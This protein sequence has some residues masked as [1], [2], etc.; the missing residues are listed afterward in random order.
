MIVRSYCDVCEQPYVVLLEPSDL[1]LMKQI[2]SADGEQVP[3]PRL[4]GVYISL[5]SDTFKVPATAKM[6]LQLNG[7]Q[8]YKAVNGAGL[9]DEVAVTE[10]H[11][12]KL[13]IGAEVVAVSTEAVGDEV[14]LHELHLKNG[15]V[16]HLTGGQRGAKVLKATKPKEV[17]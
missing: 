5:T 15:V 1:A 6:P 3:C 11:L 10:R 16:L 8:L 7:K 4:C 13:I 14:Y 9:P 12:I 2:S 17:K